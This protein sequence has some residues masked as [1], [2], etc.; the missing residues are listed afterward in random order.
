M[1][2]KHKFSYQDGGAV[3]S[4]DAETAAQPKALSPA[5]LPAAQSS[6]KKIN[7]AEKNGAPENIEKD[8]KIE[9]SANFAEAKKKLA[10]VSAGKEKETAPIAAPQ[11]D[12]KKLQFKKVSG[13]PQKEPPAAPAKTKS[14]DGEKTKKR[15]KSVLIIA[16]ASLL[17]I[18]L[19]IGGLG[20]TGLLD[21]SGILSSFGLGQSAS[22]TYGIDSY[23]TLMF[24]LRHPSLKSD[25]VLTLN[26]SYVVD[27]DVEFGGFLE[28]PLVTFGGNGSIDFVNGIVFLSGNAPEPDISRA[29]FTRSQLYIEAPSSEL[30]A[31]S[32]DDTYIN[33]KTLNGSAHVRDY[34]L[35]FPGT[36]MTVPIVFT[37]LTSSALENIKINLASPSFLFVDGESYIIDSI[38]AGGAVTAE[39]PVVAT[40]AGRLLI[41]GYAVNSNGEVIVQGTS[42]VINIF[43]PGYYA[44]DL[45]THTLLSRSER[46]GTIPGNI[47]NG[48]DHGLSYIFSV[49]NELEAEQFTQQEVDGITGDPGVFQQFVAYE[50]GPDHRHLL[51]YDSDA[52][53]ATNYG[54][55]VYGYGIWTYQA[56]IDEVISSGGIPVMPHF[57]D[58]GDITESINMA[59]F[60]SRGASIEVLSNWHRYAELDSETKCSLNT[61]NARNVAGERIYAIMSSNN[62]HAEQVGTRFIK[63]FMPNMTE[64]NVYDILRNGNFYGSTGPE[65]R[66]ELGGYQM[67]QTLIWGLPKADETA[68]VPENDTPDAAAEQKTATST[69]IASIYGF[70]TSPLTTVRLLKYDI[71][72]KIPEEYP[73]TVIYEEDFTGQGVYSFR[74]E[75]A[76][77]LGDNEYYRLEIES[78]KARY[79]EDDIGVALSNPIW[80]TSGAASN[81]TTIESIENFMGA[82]VQV[83]PNGVKYMKSKLGMVPGMMTVKAAGRKVT[84]EYHKF[85]SDKLADFVIIDVATQSGAHSVEKIYLI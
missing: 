6:T 7:T 79:I 40:E 25:D 85:S 64:Q 72:G 52:R 33:V 55:T 71:L 44:G 46:Y 18:V 56:A 29:T 3:K 81:Y 84:I 76:V 36:K 10:P 61:W 20:F 68:S 12:N 45:H 48:Y 21:V 30:K 69:A 41:F 15:G 39:I 83:S 5:P 17:I 65:L 28:L 2:E 54:E 24:Y 62:I 9:I 22:N 32:V 51:I 42:D 4:D 80:V 34:E 43:G 77:E 73:V 78:E 60:S 23:E 58:Y 26:G 35:N 38:P 74:K 13:N 57:F 31:G 63:G 67:G 66:F 11:A 1:S 49:E 14:N 37:N 8:E 53:P 59:L 50:S 19:T 70:D 82:S 75:I 27:V 47:Q 16:V